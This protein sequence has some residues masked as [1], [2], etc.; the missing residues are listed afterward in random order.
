MLISTLVFLSPK[1]WFTLF[2]ATDEWFINITIQ[3]K[4]WTQK[5]ALEKYLEPVWKSLSKYPE[6]KV[7]YSSISSNVL[8]VWVNLFSKSDRDKRG[9]RNVFEIEKLITKDLNYLVSDWLKISIQTLKWWPP[10]WSPVWIKLIANDNKK[11]NTLRDVASDFEDFLKNINWTKNVTISSKD[12]PGQ[13]EFKFDRDKLAFAWLRADEILSE[14]YFYTSWIKSGSIKEDI[15]DNDIVLKISDFDEKLTPEDIKNLVV[16]TRIWKV[17]VWDYADFS[18]EKSLSSINRE[19][20]KIMIS[21]NSNLETWVL[22]TSIQP[23]LIKFARDYDYPKGISFMAGW[24]GQENKELIISTFKSLF[25]ALFLIFT[26]LVFQFNSYSQPLIILYSVVLALLWVNLWLF[27]TWNPYSMTFAIW[28]I[29][30]TWVV[31]NDAIILVDRINKNIIKMKE[32]T[33]K[34]LQIWDYSKAIIDWWKSRLQP[35]IVTT[36][37]TIFWILPLALQ[38]EFWAGLG[39]T[40]IFGLFVGSSMTLFIIPALYYSVCLHRKMK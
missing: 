40:I 30:L 27:I 36:L 9:L 39:F 20:W 33:L 24:E 13:F 11:I 1:I 4:T 8:N 35:I 6:I 19:N 10:T 25:I 37:T 38:D 29:A 21:V 15:Q 5:K 23:K 32:H 22:P 7:Y 12:N 26:I 16:N 14:I 34:N 18:L 31:V 2:P 17:R 3:A 28:F